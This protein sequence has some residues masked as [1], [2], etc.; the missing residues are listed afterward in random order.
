[1]AH[2]EKKI[3]SGQISLK[4][5]EFSLVKVHFPWKSGLGATIA[6]PSDWLVKRANGDNR[7][8]NER[9]QSCTVVSP[10]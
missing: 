4:T 10:A 5:I 2:P 8:R 6:A 1:V 7:E 3:S 9:T